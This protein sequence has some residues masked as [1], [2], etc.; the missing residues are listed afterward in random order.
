MC[1]RIGSKVVKGGTEMDLIMRNADI[2]D[3]KALGIIHS[4]S[5]KVAHKGIVPDF[6]LDN[7]TAEK[8]EKKFQSTSTEDLN[9][10]VIAIVEGKAIGFMCLDKCRAEDLDDSYGEIWGVY[11]LPDFWR[12]GIG[13]IIGDY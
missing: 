6:I 2:N 13:K 8:S 9:K 10:N 1:G 11:L 5:W 3:C 4:E 7:M 12:R